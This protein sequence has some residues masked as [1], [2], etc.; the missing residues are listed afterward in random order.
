MA[1]LAK[2]TINWSGMPGGPGFSNLYFKDISGG[3]SIDQTVVDN[4]VSKV[5][6][7]LDAFQPSLPTSIITGVSSTVEAI[8]EATGNLQA[9]YTATPAAAAGGGGGTTYAAPVGV[10]VSWF[11][12]NVINSRRVRGRT[13]IV[14]L[15]TSAY[16]A[17]GSLGTT[18]L[19]TWNAASAALI[20]TGAAAE[21]GIWHRPTTPGGSDGEF[22]LV[23][24]HRIPDMAAVLTSRRN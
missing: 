11:T 6:T 14:P 24:A 17:D 8:D 12:N 7:W 16:E 18:K 10:V 22:A 3:P 20:G 9:F 4:A 15:S 13:F 2:V 21:F 1:Q 19:V 5:D 23:T